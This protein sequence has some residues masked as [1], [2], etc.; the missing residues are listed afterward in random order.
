MPNHVI[1]GCKV[2]QYD[3]RF[4]VPLGLLYVLNKEGHLVLCLSPMAEAS[5]F[6]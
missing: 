3:A 2:K 6:F 1:C 5:M 4:L